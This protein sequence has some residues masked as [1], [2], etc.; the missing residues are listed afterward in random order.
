M[1]PCCHTGGEESHYSTELFFPS[2]PRTERALNKIKIYIYIK[3]VSYLV[4]HHDIIFEECNRFVTE[5]FIFHSKHVQVKK[6][7]RHITCERDFKL[8]VGCYTLPWK[9]SAKNHRTLNFVTQLN[10]YWKYLKV[11]WN[12]QGDFSLLWQKKK[13]KKERAW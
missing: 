6:I 7:S 9:T 11:V 12:D 2:P 4:P 1:I 5:A 3:A 8:L 13:L 10:Y